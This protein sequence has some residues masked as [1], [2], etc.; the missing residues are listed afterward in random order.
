MVQILR[1]ARSLLV[2]FEGL[3]VRED[4]Q[5]TEGIVC[6]GATARSIKNIAMCSNIVRIVPFHSASR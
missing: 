3:L 2:S 4:R 1:E 6:K 5:D